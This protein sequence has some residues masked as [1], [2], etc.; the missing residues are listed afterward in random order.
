MVGSLKGRPKGLCLPLWTTR[1]PLIIGNIPT[2]AIYVISGSVRLQYD[3]E[4][5]SNRNRAP[6]GIVLLPYSM[7]G[8]SDPSKLQLSRLPDNQMG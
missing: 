3:C 4:V 6:Q 5:E 2:L 8:I 7:P 1:Y